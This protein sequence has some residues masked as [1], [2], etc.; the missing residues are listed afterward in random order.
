MPYRIGATTSNLLPKDMNG[1]LDMSVLKDLGLN[2]NRIVDCD[3][4]FLS[5]DSS[6][7]R[8]KKI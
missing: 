6:S 4:F 7:V 5:V 2:I 1:E 8:F 3:A